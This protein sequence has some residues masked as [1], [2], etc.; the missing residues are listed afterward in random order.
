MLDAKPLVKYF[1]FRNLLLLFNFLLLLV[2]Y[3][4]I[5]CGTTQE[6]EDLFFLLK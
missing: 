2:A 4:L 3:Q 1:L 5:L 6:Y